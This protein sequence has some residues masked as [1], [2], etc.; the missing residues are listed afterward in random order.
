MTVDQKIIEDCKAGK[1]RAQSRLYK[2]FS[3]VMLGVCMR[4]SSSLAEAEDILQEG[5]IKVFSNINSLKDNRAASG[6]IRTI[7]VNTAITHCA[8]KKIYFEEIREDTMPDPEP[9]EERY[10]RIEPEVLI[11]I[12][13]TL[14]EGYRMVLNLYV[15]EGYSHKEI[16]VALNI[17]EST[18]K[19]Q[20]FKARRTIKKEVQALNLKNKNLVEDETRR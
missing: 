14:P 2:A 12:I 5:F 18:S 19:S 16:A 10:P 8:R 17:T 1:R 4:Y 6:W 20:L 9:E 7:M 15:F 13:Q 11:R 3:G